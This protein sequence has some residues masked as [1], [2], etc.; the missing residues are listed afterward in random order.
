MKKNNI[1]K[2]D[3]CLKTG[4]TENEYDDM[5]NQSRE[6]DIQ[7]LLKCRQLLWSRLDDLFIR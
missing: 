1:S 7:V 2:I 3:F 4:I 6:L 5:F